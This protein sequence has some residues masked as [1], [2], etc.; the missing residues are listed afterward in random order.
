[1]AFAGEI[2]R[3]LAVGAKRAVQ[4]PVRVVA[5]QSKIDISAMPASPCRDNPVVQGL[6][7]NVK[8][9][10]FVRAEGGGN[11]AAAAKGGIQ[12]SIG[13]EADDLEIIIIAVMG[14]VVGGP[15]RDDHAIRG[16]NGHAVGVAAV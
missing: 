10:V 2:S 11:H 3:Y 12:A 4:G 5:D 13:G 8:S 15:G 6:N 9:E 16:V 7:A 14:A 1:L